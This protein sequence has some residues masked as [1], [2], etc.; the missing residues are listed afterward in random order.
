MSPPNEHHTLKAEAGKKFKF[1]LDYILSL[2]LLGYLKSC[3]IM[4]TKSPERWA[5]AS[6]ALPKEGRLICSTYTERHKHL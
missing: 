4:R 6:A 1:I 3:V 5:R 2:R